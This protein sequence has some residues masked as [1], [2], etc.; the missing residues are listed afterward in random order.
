MLNEEGMQALTPNTIVELGAFCKKLEA[1][2][3]VSSEE[4]YRAAL[5]DTVREVS[6]NLGYTGSRRHAY[7]ESKEVSNASL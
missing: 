7:K 4:K 5:L 6:R 2:R 3:F 1:Y